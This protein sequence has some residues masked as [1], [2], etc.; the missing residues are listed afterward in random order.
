MVSDG[1]NQRQTTEDARELVRLGCRACRRGAR[2][3]RTRAAV[4]GHDASGDLY[5]HGLFCGRAALR[6]RRSAL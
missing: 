5:S 2:G 4:D 3:S 6:G 1:T